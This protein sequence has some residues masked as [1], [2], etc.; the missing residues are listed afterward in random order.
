MRNLT[1][2]IS[3]IITSVF[4]LASFSTGAFAGKKILF[5]I[6]GPGSGNPF[7][8]SVEK[9]AKEE[10]AKLGVDLVLVAPPQE[11]DVQAQINQVEDQLAKGV[12]AIALAP[13][14]PNAFAPIV[15]EAIKSGVPVVFVDTNGINEGVTFIGT[16]N[17]NG[18]E[19]AANFICDKT[20]KGSDVAILTGIESQSTALLRR[21]GAIKGFKNCGLN[22][23][24]TQTAE[25]DTAKGR[26]VTE[27]I[28]LK[29][30]NIKAIFASNDNMGLGAMQ[31][32]KDA[33]MNDVIVVGFDA[34]PDAATSILKGEMTA[35][36]AQFSYNMGAYGVK[37]ALEL[38]NGGSIDPNI[39]TGTQLVTKENAN[40]FK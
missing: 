7:W 28:I 9:G 10:A 21:D 6:K 14:D 24:A 16:N 40:D 32:L 2:I 18:A 34:T 30:P 29:N 22:I 19:L 15:D 33:D 37:Y 39:D 27:S 36:I 25:W 4:L 23:V 26:S 3:I 13:G 17:M 11:G 8:A 20:P 1:K 31:A 35:T 5:S 12:D 38:A